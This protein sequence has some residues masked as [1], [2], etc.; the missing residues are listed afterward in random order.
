MKW[1]GW[2]SGFL[3]SGGGK[4]KQKPQ[5]NA[6]KTHNEILLP[7]R[8]FKI[9]NIII[10]NIGEGEEKLDFKYIVFGNVKW[11]IHSGKRFSGFYKTKN[12]L[13]VPPSN[14]TLFGHLLQ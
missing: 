6:N 9:K 12:T 1:A 4:C 14:C 11:Y 7:I 8:T 2:H 3:H 5:E 10:T 13:I